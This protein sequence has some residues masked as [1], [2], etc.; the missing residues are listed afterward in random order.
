MVM[1]LVDVMGNAYV[2]MDFKGQI[3]QV[4]LQIIIFGSS[5]LFKNFNENFDQKIEFLVP[6][7]L[8]IRRVHDVSTVLMA[9]AGGN[10]FRSSGTEAWISSYLHL[11]SFTSSVIVHR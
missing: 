10:T 1:E 5:I 8:E 9:E 3:V 7:Y 11:P 2:T 6:Y 4:I